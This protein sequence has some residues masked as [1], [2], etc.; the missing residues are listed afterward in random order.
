MSNSDK[1]KYKGP[2]DDVVAW[3]Q[4]EVD[5]ATGFL[6]GAALGAATGALTHNKEKHVQ[7]ELAF[8]TKAKIFFEK[9]KRGATVPGDEWKA[10]QSIPGVSS[11]AIETVES[12]FEKNKGLK[13]FWHS[14]SRGSKAIV[15]AIAGAMVISTVAQIV[16]WIRGAK[17]SRAA[18]DQ[19]EDLATENQ[20][21]KLS[22]ATIETRAAGA[23]SFTS[24]LEKERAQSAEP[25]RSV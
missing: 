25:G 24:A 13:G 5:G 9:L 15:G 6:A 12:F 11:E 17:K 2:S 14:M 23:K 8:K 4:S 7:A 3:G 16:G 18:R 22:L 10:G 19:F 1:P 20:A 21:L